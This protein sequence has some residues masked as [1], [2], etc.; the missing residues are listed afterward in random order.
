MIKFSKYHG[1]GNDFVFAKYEDVMEYDF[2]KLAKYLC[3]R[4]VGIGADGMIIVKNNPLE[5]IYYNSDGSRAEMCGNGIRCFAKYIYDNGITSEFTYNVYTL[6]GIYRIN[7]INTEPFICEVNM[8]KE[9]YIPEDFGVDSEEEI[10]N[11]RFHFSNEEIIASSLLL[12]VPH[13]VVEVDHFSITE[14]VSVG[15][16][17]ETN[18]LYQEGTNVNFYQVLDKDHIKMQTF[19]RGAGLTLAC[20]TGACAVFAYLNKE[21]IISNKAIISLPLGDLEIRRYEGEIFMS[22]PAKKV[23]DI[24]LEIGDFIE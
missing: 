20:G 2:D 17:L 10:K 11:K 14:M 5:M 9:S 22:G 12:G 3:D 6:A 18:P 1:L 8:G 21:Q 19:E 24:E 16:Y 13:T 7:V 15:R 4:H 23:F